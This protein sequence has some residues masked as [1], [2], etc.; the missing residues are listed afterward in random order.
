MFA[1]APVA[2]PAAAAAAKAATSTEA[3]CALGHQ[4]VN[5]L[6]LSK[7]KDNY[8]K[9]RFGS[10]PMCDNLDT[11]RRSRLVYFECVPQTKMECK[12]TIMIINMLYLVVC[13]CMTRHLE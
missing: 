9:D 1:A 11:I 2:I 6:E 12:L 5:E 7:I 8:L 4:N 10:D 3:K 13:I